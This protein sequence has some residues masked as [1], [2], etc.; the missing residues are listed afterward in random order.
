MRLSVQVT[1]GVFSIDLPPDHLVTLST[2]TNQQ[3]GTYTSP[4]SK[5]FPVP[6]EDNFDGAAHTHTY[7]HTHTVL[8]LQLSSL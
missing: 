5:P 7:T 6:Y 2:R 3:K 1:N 4:P 8:M